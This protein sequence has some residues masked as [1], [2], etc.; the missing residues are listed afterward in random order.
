MVGMDPY[1]EN[2]FPE[3]DNCVEA[4]PMSSHQP[5]Y[6]PAMMRVSRRKPAYSPRRLSNSQHLS[7]RSKIQ[8]YCNKIVQC[9]KN[10]C[11]CSPREQKSDF[12]ACE[13]MRVHYERR[14][15]DTRDDQRAAIRQNQKCTNNLRLREQQANRT[16]YNM[17]LLE[18]QVDDLQ[19]R[20][21]YQKKINQDMETRLQTLTQE[22]AR[23]KNTIED[24][25]ATS[26]YS[27]GRQKE[28]CRIQLADKSIECTNQM[29]EKD[30]ALEDVKWQ[31]KA[32]ENTVEDTRSN[33]DYYRDAWDYC[34]NQLKD[35]ISRSP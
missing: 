4:Q 31:L 17:N 8:A 33:S 22:L 34:E 13:K 28:Q 20:L 35:L 19:T 1:K 3:F 11:D 6:S 24:L 15:A 27:M 25:Q 7:R 30:D 21:Q 26:A 14:L 12:Q 29:V 2:Y 9:P 23:A 16:R 32:L 10:K 5:A 18:S